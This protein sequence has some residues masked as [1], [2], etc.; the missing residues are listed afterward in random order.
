MFGIINNA[1]SHP[2]CCVAKTILV[3]NGYLWKWK[4]KK[5][6]FDKIQAYEFAHEF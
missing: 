5:R 3:W 1:L 6:D 2:P 4:L